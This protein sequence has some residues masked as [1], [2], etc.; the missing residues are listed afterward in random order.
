M[1][2]DTPIVDSKD[3]RVGGGGRSSNNRSSSRP[4]SRIVG[5]RSSSSGSGFFN[6]LAFNGG[7][8]YK[9]YS[10]TRTVS[11]TRTATVYTRWNMPA[12]YSTY[13]SNFYGP[14]A[15]CDFLKEFAVLLT[16]YQI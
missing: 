12:Q 1:V 13:R 14:T 9:S 3:S 7:S 2:I 11:R 16:L 15:M 4:S 5:G 8:V 10:Q 6:S